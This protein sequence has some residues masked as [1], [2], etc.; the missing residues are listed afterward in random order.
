M[1]KI[2]HINFQPKINILI[3]KKVFLLIL[4]TTSVFFTFS[5]NVVIKGIAKSYAGDE[6]V[7][8]GFK[9]RLSFATEELAKATVDTSGYFEFNINITE[10]MQAYIHLYTYKGYIYIEPTK[11]YEILLPKKKEKTQADVLNP[12]FQQSSFSLRVKTVAKNDLNTQIKVFEFYYNQAVFYILDEKSKKK[13]KE[14]VSS[15]IIDLDTLFETSENEYFLNHK[16]YRYA[17]LHYIVYL[18]QLDKIIEKYFFEQPIL[19]NNIAYM[20]FFSDVFQDIFSMKCNVVNLSEIYNG[21][22]RRDFSLVKSALMQNEN[23][24]ESDF[25]EL[26][27][28]KGLFDIF[29]QN[30]SSEPSVIAIL[31][32][33]KT[34]A[35]CEQSKLIATNLLV[36]IS[37]LR[38]NNPAPKYVLANKKNKLIKSDKLKGKFV[39]LNFYHPD[40]Y[41][42]EKEIVF[43]QKIHSKKPKMLEIVTIYVSEDIQDMKD[44][45]KENKK[46]KWTFLHTTIGSDVL[47]DYEVCAYPSY[48]LTN[49]DGKLIRDY[50]LSPLDGFEQMYN[51]QLE[52]WKKANSDNNTIL[53]P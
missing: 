13:Q 39:Y 27:I 24:A 26:V 48:F 37:K 7:I 30:S 23:F 36:D 10:T 21:I 43:L 44:F 40:S 20:N 47:K 19:Y 16:K 2:V 8:Y 33:M 25:A 6:L 15:T 11:E 31:Q 32:T 41:T 50:G 49:P 14:L 51:S 9:D 35:A 3:M 34:N 1:S 42:C 5:Q 28:L 12:Y 38:L 52:K 17:N 18:K 46:Y 53:G 22:R 29:Y 45:L 4:L